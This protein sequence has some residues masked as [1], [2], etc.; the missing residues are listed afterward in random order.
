VTVRVLTGIKPTGTIHLGNLVG[1]IRP[2]LRLADA[3]HEAMYFIADYHALTTVQ[4]PAH[5]AAEM[6]QLVYEIASAWVACGLDP[7]K[8]VFYRQSDVPE[9]F[10]LSWIFQ[11]FTSKGWMNKA[12]AYK[13]LVADRT[14]DDVDA[15]INMGVYGYPILM[16]ADIVAMD[17]D[18]VPV[19]KDQVQH[20]EIARDIAQRI[21]SAYGQELLRLP[22]AKVEEHAAVLPGLDGRKMSKSYDN[23]IPLFASP[24]QLEKTIMKIAT[25]ATPREAP[26][27][28][29]TSTVFQIYRAIATPEETRAFADQYRAG[30]GWGDAKKQLAQ[31]VEAEIA[32][33]R[34][35]YEALMADKSRLDALLAGG[36]AK[37]RI[38]ARR[39]LDRIRSAIGIAR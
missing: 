2:A 16:T 21:N 35:R 9:L 22:A 1:A 28:P 30:I 14:G 19:G 7:D 11:C 36:A 4:P 18:L 34:A 10:E 37:A 20:V 33:A 5:T 31:R 17:I 12:H 24:K 29:D 6:Q 8:V 23:V 15:G 32:P 39:T 13:A 27:D 38:T 26:K 25:D 3:G